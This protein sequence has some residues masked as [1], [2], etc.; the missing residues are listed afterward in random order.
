[1]CLYSRMDKL[2]SLPVVK[3]YVAIRIIELGWITSN[4]EQ[5]KIQTMKTK[6]YV[7]PFI[8]S[9]KAGRT[10]VTKSGDGFPSGGAGDWGG[11]GVQGI[12]LGADFF[13]FLMKWISRSIH[14][15]SF[16]SWAE[17]WF[18]GCVLRWK[19][20]N[21]TFWRP[22]LHLCYTT[23][24]VHLEK[25]KKRWPNAIL[26]NEWVN[27]RTSR[28]LAHWS[29]SEFECQLVLLSLCD[30]R[31]VTSS[32]WALVSWFVQDDN[33]SFKRFIMGHLVS[34]NNV[35]FMPTT[36]WYWRSNKEQDELDSCLP[37][38]NSTARETSPEH[39]CRT[40]SWWGGLK[41]DRLEER[42][43]TRVP[44]WAGKTQEG[45]HDELAFVTWSMRK[46]WSWEGHP[47]G[48]NSLCKGKG[49]Q[50]LHD[51]MGRTAL[52][53]MWPVQSPRAPCSGLYNELD[54]MLC[55][56]WLEVPAFWTRGQYFHFT[57]AS[58]LL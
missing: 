14:I 51:G 47:G 41:I 55:C 4:A 19:F 36:C 1:M 24:S 34:S 2:W 30:L 32:L 46:N 48:R 43:S 13:F 39:E 7:F 22:F 50:R 27:V 18:H 37:G 52:I 26:R 5:K 16:I 40:S 45:L 8:W 17:Y 28:I 53:S 11:G 20:I 57:L 56:C 58:S 6:H 3:Y 15:T 9:S 10:C 29:Q 54:L 38:A 21:H 23:I 31:Q 35:P 42:L 44:L 49:D 12:L 33:I 25:K